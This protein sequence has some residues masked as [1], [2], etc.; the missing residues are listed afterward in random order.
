MQLESSYT[1]RHIHTSEDMIILWYR[2]RRIVV[3]LPMTYDD[4]VATARSTF[5]L[6]DAV[7]MHFE[8]SD[9]KSTGYTFVEIPSA[10]WSAVRSILASVH[11]ITDKETAAA[12]T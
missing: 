11:V 10:A 5:G 6:S 2:T 7:Q 1:E 8:S 3:H 12:D 9:F 4:L